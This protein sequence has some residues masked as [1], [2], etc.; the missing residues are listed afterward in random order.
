MR[1]YI[2]LLILA[3]FTLFAQ[4]DIAGSKDHKFL[5]RIEGFYIED[6]SSY[7]NETA[8]F[9]DPNTNEQVVINGEKTVIHYKLKNGLS[10]GIFKKK[11]PKVVWELNPDTKNYHIL[12]SQTSAFRDGVNKEYWYII[13]FDHDTKDADTVRHARTW[14][15]VNKTW[16]DEAYKEYTLTIVD[17]KRFATKLED[18]KDL[19]TIGRVE[20]YTIYFLTNK[21][22][23]EKESEPTINNIVSFLAKE[24]NIKITIEGAADTTGSKNYNLELSRKRATYIK[25]AIVSKGIDSKRL[26]IIGIGESMDKRDEDKVFELQLNRRTT[27]IR[28]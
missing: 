10:K 21:Y 8:K 18:L 5:P 2:L 26:K 4:K 16:K 9:I 28:N 3:P 22:K 11:D 19:N 17:E 7:T 25:D 12:P 23:Y 15:Y 24:K 27:L 1:K 6:Y 14:V 20:L 13:D